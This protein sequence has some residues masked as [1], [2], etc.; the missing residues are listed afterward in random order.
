MHKASCGRGSSQAAA[1][2][3]TAETAPDLRQHGFFSSR[4]E[5]G[6]AFA[7]VK[8]F[9]VASDLICATTASRKARKGVT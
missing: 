7:A 8:V 5:S 6:L 1:V 2:E 3:V 4:L 9:H